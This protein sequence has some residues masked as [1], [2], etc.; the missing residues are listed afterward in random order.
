MLS[1]IKCNKCGD[2][3]N[4]DI[5]NREGYSDCTLHYCSK[6]GY[7]YETG[8]RYNELIKRFIRYIKFNP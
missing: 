3:M 2:F 4:D 8:F 6:C 5:I 7:H 1:S